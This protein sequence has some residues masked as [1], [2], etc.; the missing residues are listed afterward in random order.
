MA[1]GLLMEVRGQVEVGKQGERQSQ[2][3]FYTVSHGNGGGGGS[4][5]MER[6]SS[7]ITLSARRAAAQRAPAALSPAER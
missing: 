2:A 6:Q 7:P 1:G 5:V 3:R 4:W